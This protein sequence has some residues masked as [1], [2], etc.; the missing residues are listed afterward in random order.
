MSTF[1]RNFLCSAFKRR[2]RD[3]TRWIRGRGFRLVRERSPAAQRG[4]GG[5]GIWGFS[6]RA[7]E[8]GKSRRIGHPGVFEFQNLAK[9]EGYPLEFRAFGQ[10]EIP[11]RQI[12]RSWHVRK[13]AGPSFS[14]RKRAVCASNSNKIWCSGPIYLPPPSCHLPE[15]S[16]C[17]TLLSSKKPLYPCSSH[18]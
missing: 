14:E 3:S 8:T 15:A 2:P 11:P 7:E 16:L 10:G 9:K 13:Q 6:E 12:D 1:R 4:H 18:S 5:W 17:R